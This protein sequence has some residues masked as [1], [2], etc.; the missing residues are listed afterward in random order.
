MKKSEYFEKGWRISVGIIL[1]N[2]EKKIFMGERIDNKGAWQMPQGGV[3]VA[4]NE[5]LENAAKRELYEETGV[6]SAEIIGIS[7]NWYYYNLP[8]ALRKKLWGGKFVG[9]KQKWFLFN[10]MGQDKDINLQADKKPEFHNWNWFEPL[11]ITEHIVSFK[12]EIYRKILQEF[13]LIAA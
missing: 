8:E 11:H 2:Q 10:F 12:K 6:K 3:N 4:K 1:L 5:K 9:Q 13:N 7:K